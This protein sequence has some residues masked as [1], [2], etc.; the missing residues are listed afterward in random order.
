MPGNVVISENEGCQ[1]GHLDIDLVNQ[2]SVKKPSLD[3]LVY[4]VSIAQLHK[5]RLNVQLHKV[6]L[7][8]EIA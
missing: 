2:V 1:C 7:N 6:R 4:Q 5:V 8:S 3:V